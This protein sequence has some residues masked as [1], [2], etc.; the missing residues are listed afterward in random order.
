MG[1]R[2]HGSPA[3]GRHR[4]F[5]DERFACQRGPWQARI[6]EFGIRNDGRE[7]KARGPQLTH[8]PQG[9][10]PL[11]FEADGGA[12]LA[13]IPLVS[14]SDLAILGRR[15][16]SYGDIYGQAAL[17]AAGALDI[18]AAAVRSRGAP[19]AAAATLE[20]LSNV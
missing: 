2:Q 17:R 20:Q 5:S 9:L 15:D 3:G 12:Q 7:R 8:Q 10:T 13:E 19:A 16:G 4:S 18:P 6:A 11:R 14:D 1:Y